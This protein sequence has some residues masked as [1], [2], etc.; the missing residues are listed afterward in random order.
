MTLIAI[1]IFQFEFHEIKNQSL[2]PIFIH[3]NGDINHIFHLGMN[4]LDIFQT[5]N[6]F[7][8]TQQ[9]IYE[10]LSTTEI[11]QRKIIEL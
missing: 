2:N 11:S 8:H 7:P 5:Q 1:H 4:I 9:R 3:S 10:N 6:E